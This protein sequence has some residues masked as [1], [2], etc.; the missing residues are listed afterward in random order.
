HSAKPK[1]RYYVTTPTYV[2]G[3]LR[4]ILPTRALDWLLVRM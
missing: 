3:F 1:P 4:R 2:M